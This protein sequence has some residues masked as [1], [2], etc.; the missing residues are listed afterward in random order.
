MAI[1]V[2]DNSSLQGA[3]EFLREVNILGRFRHVNLV[4]LLAF[5][6]GSP[7]DNAPA[8]LMYPR[9]A[10]SLDRAIADKDAPLLAHERIRIAAGSSAGLAYLHSATFWKPSVLHRDVKS[11]NILLA[12][13]NS[14]RLSDLGTA[15]PQADG[16]GDVTQ[17]AGVGTFG[18]VDPEYFHT[19][20]FAE[21][22]DV[23]S[24][25][26]VLLELLTGRPAVLPPPRQPP[27]YGKLHAAMQDQIPDGAGGVADPFAGWSAAPRELRGLAG[28]AARCIAG[29]G[30]ARPSA[31]DLAAELAELE[32]G[33]G[34]GAGAAR[35]ARAAAV[36]AVGEPRECVVCMAAARGAR[37]RPCHHF[38][39]CVPCA[40]VTVARGGG[41]PLCAA[42]VA[43]FDVGDFPATYAP[44]APIAR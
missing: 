27:H 14:A 5:C 12:P 17:T 9:M 16:P 21:A 42:G 26:V 11:A 38:A 22:S 39:L 35:A 33:N 28:A 43:G 13:D 37:L 15:R 24:L 4:P 23:F 8:C 7:A 10:R 29:D 40:E 34:G 1:K 19:G 36:E 2:L 32:S 3:R 18:Y 6:Q 41:C 31:A 25:G 30:A 20:T 44:P